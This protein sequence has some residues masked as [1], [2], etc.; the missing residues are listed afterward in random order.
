M[1]EWQPIE[2][3]RRESDFLVQQDGEIYHARFDDYGRMMFRTHSLRVPEKYRVIKTEM[4]GE[5]VEARVLTSRGPGIF[6]HNW[7]FWTR[8]FDFAPTEWAALPKHQR[9]V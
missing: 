9:D 8:G 1:A 2:T 5:E 6:E 4:D 3:A 7:T